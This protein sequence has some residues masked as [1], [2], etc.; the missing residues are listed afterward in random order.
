MKKLLTIHP[1]AL[2]TRDGRVEWRAVLEAPGMERRTVWFRT[3]EEYAS[4]LSSSADAF[5]IACLFYAMREGLDLRVHGSVSP[6]LIRNLYEY[7]KAWTCWRP[8]RYRRVTIEADKSP[9]E[10]LA[11]AQ[12]A[13]SAFSGGLDSCFT[14]WRQ[15]RTAI[16]AARYP[17][18]TGLMVHGLDIPVEDEAFEGAGQKSRHMLESA[19]VAYLEVATNLRDPSVDWIDEHGAAVAACLHA[20]GAQHSMALIPGT[21]F[22]Q[23]LRFPCGSNPVTDPLLSSDSLSIIYE[24]AGFTRMDKVCEITDWPE[25]LQD[26]R[27]C[28]RGPQLDRNCGVCSKCVAFGV[29]FAINRLPI[30]PCMPIADLAAT[31]RTLMQHTPLDAP[32]GIMRMQERLVLARERSIDEPWVHALEEWINMSSPPQ[33]A[34]PESASIPRQLLRRLKRL[35]SG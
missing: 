28:W 10:Q 19:G 20:M 8:E 33:P 1:E 35:R 22:Y 3:P 2:E 5:V 4:H 30:P 9:A 31:I 29:C 23:A 21:H 6:S 13:L 18:D 27:V 26:M 7:Q 25:A 15:T 11:P 17:V 12:R 32:Y 34:M 14:I 16:P 24:G